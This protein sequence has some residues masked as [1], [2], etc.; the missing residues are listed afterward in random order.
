MSLAWYG[1]VHPQQIQMMTT[2][3]NAMS[4]QAF[5]DEMVGEEGGGAG[6][7]SFQDS[8]SWVQDMTRKH[9]P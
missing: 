1:K 4:V 3:C 8:G 5:L 7:Y 9:G 6:G 2:I